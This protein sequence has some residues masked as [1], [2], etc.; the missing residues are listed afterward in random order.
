MPFIVTAAPDASQIVFD[1]FTKNP[2]QAEASEVPAVANEDEIAVSREK[3]IILSPVVTMVY[4]AVLIGIVLYSVMSN[5]RRGRESR[6]REIVVDIRGTGSDLPP[7]YTLIFFSEEPPSYP[8]IYTEPPS[9]QESTA[10]QTT[11][12][13]KH[14]ENCDD[15]DVLLISLEN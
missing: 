12:T 10:L 2:L 5:Y 14:S 3:V 6:R 7:S 9:Y 4:F 8:A 15:D 11:N 1:S 13:A